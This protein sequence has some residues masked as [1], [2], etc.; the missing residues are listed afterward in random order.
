MRRLICYCA[1]VLL[2]AAGCSSTSTQG[3]ANTSAE[4]DFR[5]LAGVYEYIAAMK[6]S[7]PPSLDELRLN[8]SEPLQMVIPRIESGDYVIF[9]GVGR[10]TSGSDAEAVLAYE[11]N[12]AQSGGVVLLRNGTVKRV[13]SQEFASMRKAR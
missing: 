10:S 5:E 4:E 3:T 12:A 9:W 6:E 2:F 11:K 1:V 13:S 8:H 7:P